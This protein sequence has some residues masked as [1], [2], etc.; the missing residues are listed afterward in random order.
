MPN[1]MEEEE[2][3]VVLAQI[4]NSIRLFL[5]LF[6]NIYEARRRRRVLLS[7]TRTSTRTYSLI[8]RGPDQRKHL[9]DIV[10]V[11]D[12]TALDSIRMNRDTFGRLCYLLEHLGGL[13]PTKNVEVREQ[14]AMF[15][16]ILAHHTK[17]VII[18]KSFKRSTFTISKYVHRVLLALLKLHPF[19][20]V[21][22][23]AAGT[24]NS[25]ERWNFFEVNNR[26]SY[27][28]YI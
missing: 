18:R 3:V 10:G 23:K 8:H 12:V 15:L 13:T 27:R 11:S 14:V 21:T 19:L 28:L 16:N 5:V 24:N 17:N 2:I 26:I 20:L 25:Y 9:N 4:F 6:M 7:R 1:M 22:P